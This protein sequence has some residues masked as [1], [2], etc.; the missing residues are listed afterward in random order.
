MILAGRV[1]VITGAS[2]GLGETIAENFVLEGADVLLAARNREKLDSVSARLKA[3]RPSEDQVV[4][5]MATD[6]SVTDQVTRLVDTGLDHFGRIDV[7]V[8][9]AGVYGP[10]GYL[11]NVEWSEWS[12][13]IEINLYGTVL[14]CKA[15]LPSMKRQRYGKVVIVSGGGATKPLPRF[16][17]YAASKAGVVR[18]A[19]TLAAEVADYGIDVNAI[20]PGSLNT[21]L[22]DQVL[23][24]G[25]ER[26]GVD[27]YESALRQRKDGGTPPETAARLA[28][29]LAS[30]ESDGIT[31]RLIAA[32]WDN[33]HALPHVREKLA[34]SDVYTLRRIIPEDR[35]WALS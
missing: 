3:C 5:A 20:S 24:A 31:G 32:V 2:Q 26:V 34:E 4:L 1:A 11:E 8:C 13:A 12:R 10:L 14:S 18:F 22:L 17:A 28:T 6:V 35:G 16:S 29:F 25:P 23:A 27:F 7:L 30:A 9:N 19:E 15:V 21:R 33:W